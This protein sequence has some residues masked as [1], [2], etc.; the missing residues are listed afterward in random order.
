M[1]TM[2]KMA[3]LCVDDDTT[4]LDSLEIELKKIVGNDYR[5]EMAESGEEAIE[6][7]HELLDSDHELA[8]IITDC[9][10]PGLRGDMFLRQIHQIVPNTIKIMLTGQADL[11]VVG[12]AVRDANLYRYLSKPWRIDDLTLAVKDGLRHFWQEK[13]LAQYHQQMMQDRE[14][15]AQKN[16]E[17]ERLNQEKNEF[18]GIAAHDLKNPLSAIQGWS[19]IVLNDNDAMSK[20]EI[21][22]ILSTISTI[23]RQMFTLIQNLLDVNA[24]ESGKIKCSL[25]KVN[26]N[27]TLQWL[28]KEYTQKAKSK[29]ILLHFTPSNESYY[30]L[31]DDGLARQILDNLL[32]NAIKY[33]PKGKHIYVYLTQD[34]QT[35]CCDIQDQGPGLSEED[36]THLFQ[37]FTR[38]TPRPTGKEHSNGLGLFI[39]KK[40]AEMMNAHI[41][42]KSQLNEGSHF[43][44]N[45]PL[46]SK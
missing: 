30:V 46:Y 25:Q 20:E 11:E 19:D 44:V 41:T 31:A 1:I 42:C 40:L 18:L 17:L 35:V 7:C 6:V 3:I 28:V 22:D 34:K 29:D 39:V 14:T 16:R 23:S 2:D 8:L 12:N 10:M 45:F 5:L 21:L 9:I 33:S 24:I 4:I 13:K 43:I 36:Q 15:L 27:L 26:L 38:L 32:S 37:K